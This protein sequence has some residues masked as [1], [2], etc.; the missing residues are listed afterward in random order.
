MP[1]L[2]FRRRLTDAEMDSIA[3][4]VKQSGPAEGFIA[5][6]DVILTEAEGTTFRAA[7]PSSGFDVSLYAIPADQSLLLN[8]LMSRRA[9]GRRAKLQVAMTFFA[10]GPAVFDDSGDDDAGAVR[11]TRDT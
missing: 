7:D 4:V 8:Q 10:L 3:A 2:R 1:D 9:V 5:L 6:W 11:D